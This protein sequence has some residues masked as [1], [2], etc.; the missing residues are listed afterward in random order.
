MNRREFTVDLLLGLVQPTTRV[1]LH[2]SPDGQKLIVHGQCRRRTRITG[3]DRSYTAT[4]IPKGM[5]GSRLFV[6][7]T[8]TGMVEEPFPPGAT[9]WGAQW[10]PDGTL[11]AAY[12]QDEG[13]AC[14]GTWER[15]SRQYRLYPHVLVRP[16]FGFEAIRWTPDSRSVMVKVVATHH[17]AQRGFS[18]TTENTHREPVTI[19]SF[20]PGAQSAEDDSLHH[21][22]P[23]WADGYLC[24]L[25]CIDVATGNVLQLAEDWRIIGGWKVAPDGR[26]VAIL[27]YTDHD[28][29]RQQFYFDLTVLS[30]VNGMSHVLAHR[31]AQVYGMAFNWSPDSRQLAYTSQERGTNH[32]IFVVRADGSTSPQELSDPS[33]RLELLHEDVE[34]PRWSEDGQHLYCLA[35]QGC[36][37]F[38]ADGNAQRYIPLVMDRDV[39][40]WLQPPT[41]GT[42]WFPQLDTLLYLTRHPQTQDTGLAFVNMNSREGTLLTE[43]PLRPGWSSFEMEAST[44]RSSV[45]LFL[46]GSDQPAELWQ[47]YDGYR[48]RKRLF[49]LNP[50][51]EHV[52]LGTS[53][54]LTYQTLD[55]EQRQ[56]ALLLPADYTEGSTVPVVVVVYGGSLQSH[57]LHCFGISE[58]LLHGQLLA[59]HG[60]AVLCPDIPL[61][62]QDPLKQLPTQVL[63][64][65]THLIHLGIADPK[66]IGLMGQSYGGYCTLALLTQTSIFSAAVSNAGFY[67]M[68]STYLSLRENG[69]DGWLGW[70]ESG[71]GRM[72]GSLWEKCDAYIENSPIFYLDRVETPVLLT[73]GSQDL[74]P[75]AQAEEVFVGL[76]RL[77]KKVELRR[78]EGEDHWPGRWSEQSYRDLCACVLAWFDEHLKK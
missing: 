17:Q 64:A 67:D 63:P 71:Q 48:Q 22:M 11:L 72:G 65:I 75:P 45:Y 60:Y 59:S 73:C 27:R 14:L 30:L 2:L 28:P 16:F 61:K 46:E 42:V 19:F 24:N 50:Q 4:G 66:R 62:D 57:A 12:V 3:G 56:A 36:W 5:I 70:C 69:N 6:V 25:A 51:L 8:T 54:L 31:V 32:R 77:G 26:A 21:P 49:A 33:E 34:A 1:P 55:G 47:L 37:E 15:V 52:P 39:I 38:A 35:Q 40:G 13:A 78:Y 43:F 10:S 18:T 58:D 53:R 74:V 68:I 41:T 44:D 29:T 23:G 20:A 7:D 9:C 76:R